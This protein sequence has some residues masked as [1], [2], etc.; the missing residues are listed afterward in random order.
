[1]KATVTIETAAIRRQWILLLLINPV[2]ASQHYPLDIS[3]SM[4]ER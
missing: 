3:A 1:M 4:E 2:A